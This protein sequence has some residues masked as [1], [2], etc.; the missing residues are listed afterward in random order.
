MVEPVHIFLFRICFFISAALV[1]V[2]LMLL[3]FSLSSNGSTSLT[4]SAVATDD[5]NAF[6]NG[7]VSAADTTVRGITNTAQAVARVPGNIVHFV[8]TITDVRAFIKPADSIEVPVIRPP[9][10][11]QAA[12]VITTAAAPPPA[13]PVQPAVA[14]PVKTIPPLSP[15][16]TVNRYAWGN[17]TWWV[18]TQR[19]QTGDPISGSWGNAS[20]W[21]TR[22]AASGYLVDHHPTTG[23]IM[24]TANS[25]GGL[26]HVAFVESVDADGTW[27]ISEMNV[28][29]L[30]VVDRQAEPPSAAAA[31]NFIHDRQ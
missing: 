26:G 12:H 11:V 24:Q 2:A 19:A 5:L 15:A 29:G 6:I 8:A 21:A 17:C 23:A 22:A 16:E 25:A 1:T 3:S 31:Y 9:H 27:H 10:A 13:P 28:L 7:V 18:A 4:L 30:G 20:V 14:A